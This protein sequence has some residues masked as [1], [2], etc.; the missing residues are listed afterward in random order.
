MILG[1]SDRI[2]GNYEYKFDDS[3]LVVIGELQ[4]GHPAKISVSKSASSNRVLD[5]SLALA[6]ARV[7]LYKNNEFREIVQYDD[8]TKLYISDAIMEYG[9][10][11]KIKVV[12]DGYDQVASRNIKVVKPAMIKQQSHRFEKGTGICGSGRS[13]RCNYVL[14]IDDLK[15]DDNIALSFIAFEGINPCSEFPEYPSSCDNFLYEDCA[16]KMVINA[17]LEF[18]EDRCQ[19]EHA[20]NTLQCD[21]FSSIRIH[22]IIS[23]YSIDYRRFKQSTDQP[24]GY[25]EGFI[26]P[27]ATYSNIDGGLG[28]LYSVWRSDTLTYTIDL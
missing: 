2:D 13:F 22:Y 6:D 7:E 4:G 8:S 24:V 10:H 26:E 11:Y 19:L 17:P 21:N 14:T 16:K 25:D 5:G 9:Q 1:C 12:S 18:Q 27:E 20:D 23:N 15:N 28:V 3:K